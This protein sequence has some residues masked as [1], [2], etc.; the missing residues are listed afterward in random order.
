MLHGAT[1]LLRSLQMD[2]AVHTERDDNIQAVLTAGQARIEKM[3]ADGL[4]E[5]AKSRSEL[6]ALTVRVLGVLILGLVGLA[7]LGG[8]DRGALVGALV[9]TITATK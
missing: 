4:A 1:D 3:F 7:G 6:R 9:K 5:A 2:L 8:S